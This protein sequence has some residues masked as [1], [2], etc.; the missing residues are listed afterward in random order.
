MFTGH[1]F[2]K[3]GAAQGLRRALHGS[4]EWELHIL[5]EVLR[6]SGSPSQHSARPLPISSLVWLGVTLCP[7][8]PMLPKGRSMGLRQECKDTRGEITFVVARG[9]L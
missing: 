6:G 8:S 1:R 4:R 5:L 3:L 7:S 9:Y 2:G